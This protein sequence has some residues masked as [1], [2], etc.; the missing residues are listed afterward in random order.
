MT[1]KGTPCPTPKILKS[2]RAQVNDLKKDFNLRKKKLRTLVKVTL[3]I[4]LHS[5]GL[6][7]KKA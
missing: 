7:G 6:F 2:W 4:G 5:A 1:L 3:S